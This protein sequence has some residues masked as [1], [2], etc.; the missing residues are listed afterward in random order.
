MADSTRIPAPPEA[1]EN[2]ELPQPPSRRRAIIVVV[3]VVLAVVAVAL[4]WHGTFSEDT[5]DAQVN[6]HL[7]QV[8]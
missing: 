4:W 1:D 5:D 6:G 8:S 3:V 7:I 2:N